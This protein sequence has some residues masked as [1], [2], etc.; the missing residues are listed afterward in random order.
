[1][2]RVLEIV[3]ICG[4]VLL[5][6]MGALAFWGHQRRVRREHF[7]AQPL[8]GWE[9]E[10]P[11]AGWEQVPQDPYGVSSGRHRRSPE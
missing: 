11:W 1:M 3:L 2:V 5:V 6:P 8:L 4:C 9:W 7:S 10:T